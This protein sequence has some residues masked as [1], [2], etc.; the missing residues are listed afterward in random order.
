LAYRV[1][2]EAHVKNITLAQQEL[3]IVKRLGQ[4]RKMMKK[5]MNKE[6]ESLKVNP[7][8]SLMYY[9]M[10]FKAWRTKTR[11][12][13]ILRK[14][15]IDP[16]EEKQNES[17]VE[18]SE[19]SEYTVKIEEMNEEEEQKDNMVE[20]SRKEQDYVPK[21]ISHTVYMDEEESEQI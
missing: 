3:A 1:Y 4:I 19:Y 9:K 6:R 8:L 15:G 10:S 18:E 21:D 17:I 16:E 11:K 13:Q 12:N 2:G 7:F 5:S 20:D 14:N